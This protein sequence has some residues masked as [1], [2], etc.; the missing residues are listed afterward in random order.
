MEIKRVGVVGCGIMGRGIVQVCAQ[1]GYQVV[2]SEIS[3]ELLMNGLAAITT[4]F[5]KL[6]EKGKITPGNIEAAQS[7]IEA[8]TEMKAFAACDMVIEAATEKL[9]VKK[10]IFSQLDKVCHKS[11][12]L[13]TNTSSVSVTHVASVTSRQDKV[14]GLHFFNPVPVMELL[15][16]VKT[17][18]TSDDTLET[19]KAF[20]KSIGKTV[21]I[22]KDTPA[23]IV[24]RLAVPF[25]LNAIRMLE[26][27]I[28][29]KEDIDTGV[30]LGLNHPMGPLTL[31]DF[32]G[33]DTLYFLACS[34]Y[35][36]TRDPM[37]IPPVLLQ[38]MVTSGR[39][40]RKTGNGFYSYS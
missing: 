40:G 2:V 38:R 13:A 19:T 24:N 3:S 5:N 21:I 26:S 30:R 35:E 31:A 16:I 36:D 12:I 22:A 9:E 8:T 1:S 15:E 34:A 29:N 37:W 7:R 32:I 18:D 27:G 17:I 25:M 4:S 23:F 14:L 20:A 10:D 11:S 39:H 28:A 33:L 6:A